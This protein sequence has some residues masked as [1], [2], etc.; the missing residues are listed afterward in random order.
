MTK[1]A[2]LLT[3]VAVVSVGLTVLA[4]GTLS[5]YAS[6]EGR[7]DLTGPDLMDVLDLDIGVTYSTE[8]AYFTSD[9]LIVLP[10][11]WVWQGFSGGATFGAFSLETNVLFSGY[12][13]EHLYTE[14]IIE[15][16]I[17]GIDFAFYAAQLREAVLGGP[18]DG[19]AVR[20]AGSVGVL[21]IVSITEFGAHIDRGGITIVHAPTGRQR[22][23]A[24]DPRAYGKGFT[25]EKITIG[26]FPFCCADID[27]ATYFTCASG[28]EY[29]TFGVT[30]LS[31][32]NLDWLTMGADL[33]FTVEEKT[34]SMVPTLDIGE[35][36]CF[37]LYSELLFDGGTM[38]ALA[39]DGIKFMS[40]E[41]ACEIGSV[42]FRDV[43]VLDPCE[44]A[45]TTEDYGSVV[46]A[47]DDILDLGYEYY[48][49]YWEMFSFAYAG[50]SCCAGETTLLA[51]FYFERDGADL[52]DLA[53]VYLEANIPIDELL[54]LSVGTRTTFP[55]VDWIKFAFDVV[56]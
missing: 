43:A 17:A 46:M 7:F 37:T 31:I 9:T 33:T 4:Q 5:G 54:T 52:F 2:M 24:T 25:G 20:I 30:D 29:I 3:M 16:P 19:W 13:A 38:E 28:F 26:G 34:L 12:L 1:R 39:V 14:V 44:I 53:A 41:L 8:Q 55:N 27:I 18:H 22:H 15:L 49:D 45:L 56:F 35:V 42:T 40:M 21:D 51:N 11:T 10:G 50:P 32:E 47:I 48:P 6:L 23:Y 36:F